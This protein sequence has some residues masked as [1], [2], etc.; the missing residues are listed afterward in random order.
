MIYMVEIS[1]EAYLK[2]MAAGMHDVTLSVAPV[3][4]IWPA[5][6]NLT[7]KGVVSQYVFENQL[8]ELVYRSRDSQYDHVLLPTGNPHRFVV[9]IVDIPSV[10][11]VSYHRLD[12]DREY[13]Q[14]PINL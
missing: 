8:V 2:S 9:I 6:A 1:K 11:L 5:V 14:T 3:V 12:L 13:G 10:Q 4:D 7:S